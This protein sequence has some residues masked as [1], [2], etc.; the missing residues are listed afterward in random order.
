MS[1]VRVRHPFTK[2]KKIHIV[3]PHKQLQQRTYIHTSRK[4]K[5]RVIRYYMPENMPDS[6][7]Y[8]SVCA[9][10]HVFRFDSEG[11]LLLLSL[12][13]PLLSEA[14]P[15]AVP[16][17][18]WSITMHISPLTDFQRVESFPGLHTLVAHTM[19]SVSPGFTTVYSGS[20]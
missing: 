18:V 15:L 7:G 13:L 4:R 9:C 20:M 3:R 12:S 6:C 8:Y 17:R 19:I 14:F 5:V 11:F 1:L 10:D 16:L 2:R